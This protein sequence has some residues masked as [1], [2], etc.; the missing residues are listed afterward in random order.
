MTSSSSPLPLAGVRVVE[1]A[2]LAP[3]P[4][5]GM[6][7]ADWGA[8]VVRVDRVGDAN[9][10]TLCRGKRSVAINPKNAQG[11]QVLQSLIRNADV[12]LDP[13]RPGV[14][15]KLGL[16]PQDVMDGPQG[17]KRLILA[18]LT[19]FQ[20]TGPYANMAGH[21]INYIALSGLLSMLGREGG[22][23]EPPQNILGDFA[24]GSFICILGILLALFERTRSGL[25]QVVNAD[26]VTGSRYLSTFN[27]LSSYVSHSVWGSI[28][29][30]GTNQTRGTGILAGEAPWYGVYRCQDGGWFSVGAIEPQFYREL[31]EK[32]RTACPSPPA[33]HTAHPQPKDQHN[34]ELWPELRSYFTSTFASRPR[35]F[36]EKLFTGSDACAVPVLTRDEAAVRGSSP[37][38]DPEEVGQSAD[39]SSP[40]QTEPGSGSDNIII[41][42]V[43]PTLT[44]TPAA[45]PHGSPGRGEDDRGAELM[46]E[47]GEH[48][49][50]VF[51]EWKVLG[52]G[53]GEGGDRLKTLWVEGAVG[54]PDSPEGWEPT[55]KAKL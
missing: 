41:P 45:I 19:G 52:A 28:F 39:S 17:N 18:R 6:V 43:A 4:M 29:N 34:R 22:P 25:G 51:K 47:A 30:D 12:L 42:A 13:F 7:L 2:G 23:P 8:D 55:R 53:E 48:T 24:G 15:E 26:M 21:D 36:F 31:L 10:D 46:L 54:G 16:G 49:L 44:R 11:R 33:P 3:V 35:S 27:L 40:S 9:F 20:R 1:F 37:F 50:E 38:A 5:V 32:L 14:L